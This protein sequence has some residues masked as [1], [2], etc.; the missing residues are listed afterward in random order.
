[1]ALKCSAPLGR[2]YSANL[3][4]GYKLLPLFFRPSVSPVL[5]DYSIAKPRF[6]FLPLRYNIGPF[7]AHLCAVNPKVPLTAPV[8]ITRT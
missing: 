7:F 5:L 1:M 6:P 2:L 4:G 3:A 8:L